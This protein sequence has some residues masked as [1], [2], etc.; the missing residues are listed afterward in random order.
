MP[1]LFLEIGC[2]EIP[3]AFAKQALAD[4]GRLLAE[5]LERARLGF[6]DVRTVGTPR[7]L[8]AGVRGVAARQPDQRREVPGPP[9]SV[10][11]DAEGKLTK[12]GRAFEIKIKEQAAANDFTIIERDTPKGKYLLGLLDV[13]GLPAD[14]VLSNLVLRVLEKLP[15]QKSMR[16]ASVPQRFVR[17]V[18]WIVALFGG[19]VIPFAFAGVESGRASR[20]HR[21]HAPQAFEVSGFEDYLERC[22]EAEVVPNPE[23]RRAAIRQELEAVAGRLGG[24]PVVDEELLEEVVFLVEKPFAIPVRFPAEYLEI[25]DFLLLSVMRKQQRYFAF[26]DEAGRLLPHF[27]FVAGTR[28]RDPEVVARGNLKV[29]RARFD[30]ALFYLREDQKKPLAARVDDLRGIVF[31]RGLGT[32]RD[33]VARVE[34]L[35]VELAEGLAPAEANRVA[36]AARLCK[37]DLTTGVVK[38]FPELQGYIGRE[39]ARR[40]GVEAEV[41]SAVFEHYRPR[42]ATDGPPQGQ[43]GAI[44]SLADKL[45]S[46]AGCFR[47]GQEPTGTADPLALRRQALGIITTVLARGYH[48]SLSTWLSRAL[49]GFDGL[50]REDPAPALARLLTF[51]EGRLRALWGAEHPADAVDAVLAAGFDDLVDARARLMA[52]VEFERRPDFGPVALTFKRVAKIL[53]DAP[54]AAVE[55]ARFE[56]EEEVALHEATA[57]IG[58]EVRARAERRD[59]AGAL[60]ELSGL[61]APVDAFFNKV[62]VMHEDPTIRRNRLALLREVGRLSHGLLDF[63]RLQAD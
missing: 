35:A 62:F 47:V 28:V 11:R 57:R 8:A 27:A 33:K 25:P 34:S 61:G 55:P 40:E 13:K 49:S 42:G 15:F 17:P 59:F 38:E 9:V 7:R 30:D 20:G 2:E 26:A 10:A 18:H 48:L 41:A 53:K 21:F 12:A 16:W 31:L 52:V 4:L 37:A 60:V 51:F 50:V 3:A 19:E 6:G 32:V 54:D 45:D 22:V 43:V 5:E 56:A 1:D 44:L 58:A 63:G 24:R 39:Y 46:L 36:L 14:E 23:A 29:A